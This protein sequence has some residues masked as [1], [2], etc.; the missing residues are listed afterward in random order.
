MTKHLSSEIKRTKFCKMLLQFLTPS[1]DVGKEADQAVAAAA[2]K[3]L[4]GR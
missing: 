3:V 4:P 2:V 1:V